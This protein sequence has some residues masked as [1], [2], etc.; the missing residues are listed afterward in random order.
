MVDGAPIGF[1]VHVADITP[2]KLLELELIQSNKKVKEQNERL[3][4]FANIVSH[5]LKSYAN[6]L[7][8]ILEMFINAK[9]QEEKEQML[10]FLKDISNGFRST[11]THLTEIVDTTN[12]RDLE[13]E[14]FSLFNSV[15]A[16]L[17]TL[18]IEIHN[19]HSRLL[20]NVSS[21]IV[22]KSNRV[23]VDSIILNLLS[24]AIKYRHPE[25]APRIDISASLSDGLLV[26]KISDNGIGLDLEKIKG[27]LFGMYQTFH[28]NP[29]AKGIGLY[30]VKSQ[31][32][33]IGGS[34]DIE[35][36]FNV[37]TTFI[38]RIAIE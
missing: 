6:N 19:T 23:Y 36:E 17:S 14:K 9:A 5:N 31:V 21:D 8:A 10:N 34:I 33:A 16:A 15:D 2:L 37:G 11:I 24:N 28:S 26:L 18:R 25:R 7:G 3:L 27:K 20:N 13:W 1:F 30:L 32:E 4:N 35:S 38:I 29:D 12:K 22:I